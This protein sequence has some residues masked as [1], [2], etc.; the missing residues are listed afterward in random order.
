MQAVGKNQVK[1]LAQRNLS[2]LAEAL[3][4]TSADIDSKIAKTELNF[5]ETTNGIQ[6][7]IGSGTT[8]YTIPIMRE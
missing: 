4:N 3:E 6:I 5:V 7:K 8:L 1:T 2:L